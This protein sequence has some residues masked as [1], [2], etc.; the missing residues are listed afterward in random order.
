[1]RAL[2]LAAVAAA[3][4]AVAAPPA[5]A[6]CDDTTP[7]NQCALNCL[8]GVRVTGGGVEVIRYYC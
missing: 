3:A 2:L 5:S 6:K 4:L 8:P 7:P 1:M